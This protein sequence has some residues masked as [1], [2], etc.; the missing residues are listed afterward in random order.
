MPLSTPAPAA[1]LP[2]VPCFLSLVI[3][4]PAQSPAEA[5]PLARRR[6]AL[7]DV[8]K[9]LTGLPLGTGIGIVHDFG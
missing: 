2:L 6:R 5:G 9:V 7:E 8:G 3:H 1:A 4:A